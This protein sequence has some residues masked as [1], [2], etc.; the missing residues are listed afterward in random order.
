MTKNQLRALKLAREISGGNYLFQLM[1]YVVAIN[2]F[3]PGSVSVYKGKLKSNKP[4]TLIYNYPWEADLDEIEGEDLER[5]YERLETEEGLLQVGTPDYG[6]Q[7]MAADWAKV[8]RQTIQRWE[9]EGLQ[10][11]KHRNQRIY[12]KRDVLDFKAWHPGNR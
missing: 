3:L 2:Y 1:A 8:S 12:L 11:I 4:D 6:D 10:S 9:K 7:E 5:E